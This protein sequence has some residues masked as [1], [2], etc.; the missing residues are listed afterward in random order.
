MRVCVEVL[1]FEL[2]SIQ[3]NL[4]ENVCYTQC[5]GEMLHSNPKTP[6]LPYDAKNELTHCDTSIKVLFCPCNTQIYLRGRGG[7][8]QDGVVE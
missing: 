6:Q 2:K 4:K 3:N 8:G 7:G 1:H 5:T